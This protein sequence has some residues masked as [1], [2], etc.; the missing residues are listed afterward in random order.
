MK[1]MVCGSI[2]YGGLAKIR[3]IQSLLKKNGFTVV[4]QIFKE[5][6]C[7]G[8][9]DFRNEQKL[10]EKVVRHDLNCV[11]KSDVIVV[12]ADAPSYG[13]AIE[14]FVAKE[15]G[16][17]VILFSEKEIPTPWSIAFSDCIVKST[18]KLI[19]RLEGIVKRKP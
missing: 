15:L 4:D 14:M 2:G 8:I 12:M 6:V 3:K 13:T 19:L 17:K 16:K 1:I 10:A 5:V 18:E 7:S 9:K 11:K